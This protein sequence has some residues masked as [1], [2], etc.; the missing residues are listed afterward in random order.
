MNEL[1]K[2]PAFMALCSRWETGSQGSALD[3]CLV[4]FCL[5]IYKNTVRS[6]KGMEAIIMM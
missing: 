6:L 4:Y 2:V 3:F 5:G 1:G